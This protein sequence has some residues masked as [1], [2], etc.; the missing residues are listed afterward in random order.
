DPLARRARRHPLP[1]PGRH[2]RRRALALLRRRR[3]PQRPPAGR[4]G[5]HAAHLR[6]LRQDLRA[7]GR[8]HPRHHDGGRRPIGPACRLRDARRSRPA[9][10]PRHG[11]GRRARGRHRHHR[12]RQLERHA[13]QLRLRGLLDRDRARPALRGPQRGHR[14]RDRPDRRGRRLDRQAGRR[15]RQRQHDR[16]V[17]AHPHRARRERRAH[18]VLRGFQRGSLPRPDRHGRRQGRDDRAGDQGRRRRDPDGEP[19]LPEPA[20]RRRLA[21]A[22]RRGRNEGQ[23]QRED[24]RGRRP[25]GGPRLGRARVADRR[26]LC[27]ADPV[28]PRGARRQPARVGAVRLRRRAAPAAPGRGHH[29][30]LQALPGRQRRAR[31]ARRVRRA[32]GHP[33]LRP[34]RQPEGPGE[35]RARRGQGGRHHEPEPVRPQHERP[36]G[37]GPLRSGERPRHD[38]PGLRQQRRARLR[39]VHLRRARRRRPVRAPPGRRSARARR[40]VQPGRRQRARDHGLRPALALARLRAVRDRRRAV[41][42]PH[43]RS[44]AARHGGHRPGGG[45]D[46]G[47]RRAGRRDRRGR[48]GDRLGDVPAQR[49]AVRVGQ[50]AGR[51]IA[52]Q[53]RRARRVL[54]DARRQPAPERDLHA[55]GRRERRDADHDERRAADRRRQPGRP[56]RRRQHRAV[57]RP[58]RQG[59]AHHREA[60]AVARP[61]PALPLHRLRAPDAARRGVA[62]AGLRLGPLLRADQGGSQDHLHPPR[63]AE[64]HVQLQGAG[65]LQE[66]Q[67]LRAPLE[68]LH[69][70]PLPGQRPPAGAERPDAAGPRPL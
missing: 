64:Q 57:R 1:V 20:Q 25:G 56:E 47:R 43:P 60:Q 23:Q 5:G 4:R 53:R 54:G 63:A 42:L 33:G 38:E 24:L 40:G 51:R 59:E 66:P 41:R 21:G 29:D 69:P 19:G 17:L 36:Q 39:G 7:A 31:R 37:H 27:R 15:G 65:L 70:R 58:P 48:P 3:G 34:G 61:A 18:P 45:A 2:G 68:A 22:V 9:P 52:V 32:A 67:A 28:G 49:P 50:R 62:G 13:G 10:D 8:H 46:R 11:G 44:G 26:Q 30:G 14:H 16:P 55:R 35:R 6:L 12:G